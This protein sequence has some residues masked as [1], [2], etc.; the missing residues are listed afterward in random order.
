MMSMIR[1]ILEVWA[2]ARASYKEIHQ[3]HIL[4]E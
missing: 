1:A 2:D 4:W 3:T